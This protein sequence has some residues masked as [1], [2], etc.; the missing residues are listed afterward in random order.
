ME[1]NYLVLTIILMCKK[2]QGA[3]SEPEML[4]VAHVRNHEPGGN[5]HVITCDKNLL[6]YSSRFE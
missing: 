5:P 3:A 4:T 6:R 2:G 1:N